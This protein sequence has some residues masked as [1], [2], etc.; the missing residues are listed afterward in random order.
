MY[1]GEVTRNVSGG[2]VTRVHGQQGATVS[3]HSIAKSM[4]GQLFGT[5]EGVNRKFQYVEGRLCSR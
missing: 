5:N 2:E 1:L 3:P 4:G